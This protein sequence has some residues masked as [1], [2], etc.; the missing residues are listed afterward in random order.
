M[1]SNVQSGL[2]APDLEKILGDSDIPRWWETY[3]LLAFSGWV[4]CHQHGF[5]TKKRAWKERDLGHI[6]PHQILSV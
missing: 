5:G 6:C 4:H 2:R 1:V 3:S